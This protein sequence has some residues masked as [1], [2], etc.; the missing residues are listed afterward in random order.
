MY[1][2]LFDCDGTLIDSQLMIAEAMRRGF[3]K[4][5]LEAPPT[6]EI[7]GIVGLSLG[8]AV[9]RLMR[10]ADAGLVEQV[11]GSYRE[12][13]FE[14]RSDPAYHEPLYDGARKA[15]R[16]LGERPDVLLGIA[17][18]KSRR[19]VAAV[20]ET[21][22]LDGIFVTIQT[23]DTH[24]SKPHPAMIEAGLRE[25][26]VEA[27]RCVIVGDTSY[28]MLMARSAGVTG[29]GVSWGYHAPDALTEAGAHEVLGHFDAL[30]PALEKRFGWEAVADD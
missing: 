7:L 14:L 11:A 1:L 28:D 8:E 5:G 4:N 17:T 6:P 22:A 9:G 29:F 12:A 15:V 3:A 21:H 23:S 30:Y 18:G 27:D 25:A 26:G 24:P 20:L 10:H 13:F 2:I 19:G 16:R